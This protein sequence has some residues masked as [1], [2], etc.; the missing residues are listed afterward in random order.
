MRR[1]ANI[2]G[3]LGALAAV[4]AIV[5]YTGATA[6]ASR[7]TSKAAKF[8]ITFVAALVNDSYFVTIKCGALAEAKKLGVN[9]KWTGP[10][11]N[12]VSAEY[13]AFQAAAV[14]NP[15]AMILA[16]FS[17]NGFRCA[18]SAPSR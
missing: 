13:S 17:N 8:N 16:P 10:A 9:L 1:N 3:A 14:T 12:S 15:D 11:S 2:A 18:V 7:S 4:V 6:N 5:A